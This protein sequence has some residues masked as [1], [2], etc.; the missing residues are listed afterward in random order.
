MERQ[1]TKLSAADLMVIHNT[2]YKSLNVIG[3]S[4][5]T[6]ETRERVMDKV[7][8]I[9]ENMNAEVVC[10]DVEPIVVSGDLGG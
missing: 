2:L 7:S 6:Q 4:I 5:W 8:L 1:M 3:S 10:G 9:M